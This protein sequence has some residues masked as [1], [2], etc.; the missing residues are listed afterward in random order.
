MR[1]IVLLADSC[2]DHKCWL[3]MGHFGWGLSHLYPSMV[4]LRQCQG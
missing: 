4:W 2:S 1:Q 3:D